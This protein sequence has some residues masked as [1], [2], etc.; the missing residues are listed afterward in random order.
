METW[1]WHSV[2]E[3]HRAELQL[4]LDR[5][6]RFTWVKSAAERRTE[7]NPA[8]WQRNAKGEGLLSVHRKRKAGVVTSG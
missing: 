7:A 2:D 6:V 3:E 8:S 5:D 1:A 4:E